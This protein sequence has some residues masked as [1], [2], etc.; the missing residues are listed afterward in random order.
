MKAVLGL[1]LAAAGM[2]ADDA[3]SIL[4]RR[5]VTCHN[6]EA[7]MNGFDVSTR[8][9]ILKG[10]LQGVDIE[11]GNPGRSRLIEFVSSGKM[12]PTGKLP[13]G[14]I[15]ALSDWVARG[16]PWS[17]RES[18]YATRKRAGSDWWALQPP[19][20]RPVPAIAG[21]TNPIDAFVLAKLAEKGLSQAP[22]ADHRTLVRR[23][24]FD[25]S[26]LPPRVEDLQ[27]AYPETIDKLLASTAYGERW[28]RHWLDLARFGETDGG[29]HNNER[30]TAWK[31]RDY[32]I[33]AFNSDKP[34]DQFVRE[35]VAGDLMD[36]K[37]ARATGFLVSGPWDSVTKQINKDELMA[38]S[39]RQDELDDMVTATM[40]TFMGL[41]V[42]CARCHD[43][44]FDPI[45]TRDYYRLTAVFHG[46]GFGE[47]ITATE[48]EKKSREAALKPLRQEMERIKKELARLDGDA[49]LRLLTGR[50]R[51]FDA[52]RADKSRQIPV[53]EVWNRNRF[54]AV[55]ASRFRMVV[56]GAN[57]KQVRIRRFELL[58]GGGKHFDWT[59]A[60]EAKPDA[61]VVFEFTLDRP[62]TASE[63]EWSSGLERDG[64]PRVYRF[65]Y[66]SDGIEWKLACSSLDHISPIE[67]LLPEIGDDEVKREL[68]E[69]ARQQWAAL[70]LLRQEMQKRIDAVAPLESVHAVTQEPM[71][72]AYVLERGSLTKRGAEAGPGALSAIR[73]LDPDLGLAPDAPDSERR[74]ALAQW[75]TDR[76]N[77]LTARVM[78]NRIW[79]WHFG[80][81]IVN[82]PS[83]FG[84][85]G[86]R[87]SHP[88][89]L[90][91][92]A[93]EFM[94]R[95]WSVKWLQRLIVTS[96]TYQQSS[97]FNQ[98]AHAVD[99]GNRLLWHMPL[100]RMD[101]E[102][103]RDSILKVA[104]NLN[105]DRGG[106]G[107]LLQKKAGGGSYMYKV[108]DYDGPAVWKRGVYRFVVRGGERIFVDSFDCPDPAVAAPER[109]ASNTPVQALTL[110]NNRFVLGQ[111]ESLAAKLEKERPDM[112][113]RIARAYERIFQ[114]KPNDAELSQGRQFAER[115]GLALYVRALLNTNE[116]VYVP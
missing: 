39:I 45:P 12:P 80:S 23:L 66:S 22:A 55:T 30:F 99:A 56:T 29:E 25:L 61:P 27:A 32:V 107:F 60:R 52:G 94:D 21:A 8:S 111:A 87:P 9:A 35:Q 67:L 112:E 2:R 44:K 104:G 114:R 53:N 16:A 14:E 77:P 110:L 18:I 1:L 13:Q 62:V 31:Y 74:L 33:D 98:A 73:A 5:C 96:R 71:K 82:T 19:V 97:R 51:E 47:R 79:K 65:E 26:G 113:G 20:R 58:P 102:T 90:D 10:G 24:Y 50:Y 40:A 3:L 84:F 81:G 43:H 42:N 41:T 83:D 11:P 15:D 54:T 105:P 57:G 88:E 38:R 103:L 91:W 75:L 28:A 78:V 76:N 59:E 85:N 46:A 69:N 86:D 92:L 63:I 48:E 49:R 109:S 100:K 64:A 108:V 7:K 34:Y 68:P 72:P 4:E 70:A 106:P 116:F 101:A 95:G 6:P 36:R 89:L 115:F 37:L 17:E 93:V